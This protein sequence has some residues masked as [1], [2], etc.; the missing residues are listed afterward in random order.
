M[1]TK[2]SQLEAGLS[3]VAEWERRTTIP[4]EPHLIVLQQLVLRAVGL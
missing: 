1:T 3:N 4:S 2:M